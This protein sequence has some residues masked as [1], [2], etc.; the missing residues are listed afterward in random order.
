MFI[1][2]WLQ[3]IF[4]R[5]SVTPTPEDVEDVVG[6]SERIV[7]FLLSPLH[8][9]NGKLRSNAFN[10]TPGSDEI[11]VNRLEIIPIE[12]TKPIAKR[13][14]ITNPTGEYCGFALHTKRSAIA[15]GA[16]EVIPD[17]LEDNEAHAELKLGI[18]REGLDIPP[19]MQVIKD[20]LTDK[21]RLL[22]DPNP[23]EEGWKGEEPIYP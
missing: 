1:C 21:C 10:P 9:K 17:K 8:F 4:R 16:K 14:A 12:Q 22:M 7:R 5:Q 19:K 20:E 23:N 6:E 15:C 11:S 2:N 18:I 13:M 3:K